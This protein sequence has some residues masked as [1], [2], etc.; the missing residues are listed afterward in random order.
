MY[1]MCDDDGCD[2]RSLLIS[3]YISPSKQT[4]QYISIL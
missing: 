3:L 2:E 1:G 4:Y